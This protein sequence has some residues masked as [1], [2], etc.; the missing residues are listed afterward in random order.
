[1]RESQRDGRM[2]RNR[3][4][5]QSSESLKERHNGREAWLNEGA[6]C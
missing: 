2:D 6:N 5:R 1:M 4:G 3:A